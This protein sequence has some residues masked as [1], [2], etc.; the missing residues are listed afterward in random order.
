MGKLCQTLRVK[1][2]VNRLDR[3]LFFQQLGPFGF[4]ALALAGII[5]LA[6]TL[7]LMEVIIDNGQSGFI[8]LE[9]ATLIL[10][11]V[12]IVVLPISVFVSTMFAINR[13][14]GESEMVVILA[15]GWRPTRIIRATIAVGLIV[16]AGMT[17]LLV[18]LQPLS[19]T[20]L[21]ARVFEVRQ[22]AIGTLLKEKQFLHPIDGI[23]IY[24]KDSSKAG[25]I[26]GLFLHD[27]T[28]FANPVTYSATQALLL[29]DGEELRLVMHQGVMQQYSIVDRTLNTIEFEKFVFDLS[30]LLG[31]SGVRGRSPLEYGISDLLNPEKIIAEGGGHSAA[32]YLAEGHQKLALPILGLALPIFA[33]A[34]LMSANYRRTGLGGRIGLTGAIGIFVMGMTLMIKTWVISNPEF[35]LAS[36]APPLICLI[37]AAFLLSKNRLNRTLRRPMARA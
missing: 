16:T 20:R 11:N 26:D 19:A 32:A 12:L 8:F 29:Q 28:D 33:F 24:I 18:I 25:E 7:P 36:Y 27:Q 15:A 21:A 10:P 14:F 34:M 23:T 22:D 6:Q 4:F 37:I 30:L 3:Y 1:R 35:F 13:L 31:E 2:L 9:F 5:W 17:V